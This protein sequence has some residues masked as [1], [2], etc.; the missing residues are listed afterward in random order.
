MTE[1]HFTKSL[2][3]TLAN[4]LVRDRRV[5]HELRFFVGSARSSLKDFVS[6]VDTVCG[7]LRQFTGSGGIVTSWA[8]HSVAKA[9]PMGH[10]WGY[11]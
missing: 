10:V 4:E 7:A 6:S 11:H 3:D 1:T 8:D 2:M 5:K 9:V